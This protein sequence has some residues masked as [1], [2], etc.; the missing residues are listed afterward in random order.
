MKMNRL[1]IVGLILLCALPVRAAE[2]AG[3]IVKDQVT[4]EN[5]E[6]LL[7]NGTGLREKFWIDVYVG[8]L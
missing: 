1:I 8:S 2:L 4:A 6:T 5:G 7:L 3:V